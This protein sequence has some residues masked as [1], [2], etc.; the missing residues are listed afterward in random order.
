[1]RTFLARTFLKT[2]DCIPQTGG[3]LGKIMTL[4][5][6]GVAD[7]PCNRALTPRS[8]GVEGLR[9][10]EGMRLMARSGHQSVV[11]VAPSLNVSPIDPALIDLAHAA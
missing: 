7:E 2:E 1:L 3:L 6:F 8:P 4:Q 5:S 10:S 11:Q 9:P